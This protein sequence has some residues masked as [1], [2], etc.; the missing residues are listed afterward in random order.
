MTGYCRR[1]K[2]FTFID[3]DMKMCV[4]CM[5]S[6]INVIAFEST[7]TERSNFLYTSKQL[8]LDLPEEN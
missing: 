4:N 5:N 7:S 3:T 2:L 1:C 8:E 6:V